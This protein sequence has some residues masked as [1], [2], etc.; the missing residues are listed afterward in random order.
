MTC[1]T[2]ANNPKNEAIKCPFCAHLIFSHGKVGD[3]GYCAH[4]EVGKD[5]CRCSKTPKD[6]MDYADGNK[7]PVR[8]EV[9]V[10]A[11]TKQL[12]VDVQKK[13]AQLKLKRR[14]KQDLEIEIREDELKLERLELSFRR[15]K[16]DNPA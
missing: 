9:D 11:R 13:R 14:A 6:L 7:S 12:A 3:K 2:K 4:T 1:G 8:V 15:W 10:R 5:R 16:E